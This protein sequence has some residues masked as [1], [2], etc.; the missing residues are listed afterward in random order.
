MLKLR[1]ESSALKDFAHIIPVMRSDPR[2]LCQRF[3]Q[4]SNIRK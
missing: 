4:A 1:K 3:V 2:D